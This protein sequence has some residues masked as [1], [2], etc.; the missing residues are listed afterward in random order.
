[1][2]ATTNNAFA[3]NRVIVVTDRGE[4]QVTTLTGYLSERLGDQT[5]NAAKE[6][7]DTMFA[8]H[9]V[10]DG[11]RVWDPRAIWSRT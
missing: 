6:K 5:F 4:T 7:S 2:A 9:L 3:F 10:G 8:T 1:M 11:D